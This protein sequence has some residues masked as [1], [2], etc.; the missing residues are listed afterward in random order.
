VLLAL[1]VG[2]LLTVIGIAF[3]L[4]PG[5]Q[6]RVQGE[7]TGSVFADVVFLVIGAVITVVAYSHRSL[8]WQLFRGGDT[9]DGATRAPDDKAGSREG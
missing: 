3:V 2:P 6:V 4:I 9:K 7:P 5:G 8:A 1:A